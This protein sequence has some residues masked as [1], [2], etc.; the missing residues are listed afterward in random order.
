MNISIIDNMSFFIFAFCPGESEQGPVPRY[1]ASRDRLVKVWSPD[2]RLLQDLK[3]HAHWVRGLGLAERGAG[4]V[5][6]VRFLGFRGLRF[7]RFPFKNQ[8]E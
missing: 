5:E 6:A 2:G 4:F 3:G 7:F 1:S 8:A